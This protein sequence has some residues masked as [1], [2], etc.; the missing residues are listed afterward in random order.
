MLWS[1]FL[2]CAG[3]RGALPVNKTMN[4]RSPAREQIERAWFEQL[5]S[6]RKAYEIAAANLKQAIEVTK[7]S[8]WQLNLDGQQAL[9]R[10]TKDEGE[11]I[12]RYVQVLRIFTD[13]VVHGIMPDEFGRA[14]RLAKPVRRPGE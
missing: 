7:S 6:A 13:L 14:D 10:A 11:A 5:S 8:D 2:G 12:K 1:E 9:Y 3:R 4:G